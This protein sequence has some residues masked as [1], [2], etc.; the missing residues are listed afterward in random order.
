MNEGVPVTTISTARLRAEIKAEWLQHIVPFWMNLKDEQ[1]GGYYGEV[2]YEL[3]RKHN[4]P[5][6]GIATARL[7]W[8][9]AAAYRMTGDPQLAEHA[10]HAY[11]F[12]SGALTDAE[13][14][15]IYWSVDHKGK[16]LDTRKHVY[17]QAF[18]VYAL[19]EYYRATATPA[20]LEQAIALFE[21]I[22]SVG[23]DADIGAYREEF[24][25]W[26][27][28][29]PNEMLSENGV[30]AD[31]TMNTHIHVLEAYT[32]LYRV[33]Q[34]ERV[35]TALERLLIILRHH[36]YDTEQRRLHVF[37]DRNWQSLLDLTSFGHDIE[38]SWLID[39]A[40]QALAC[41]QSEYVDMVQGLADRVAEYAIQPDG[42][43]IN[44]QEHD[45]I[46]RT[47]IWWVQ[48]EAMV[49]FYN[50]YQRTGDDRFLERVAGL[51]NY[52][53]THMIDSRPGSEWFW[54]VGDDEQPGTREIAGL[55][56]CP[57]HN[58]RFCIEMMTRIDEMTA[59]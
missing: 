19:S 32:T 26:W 50:A 12:L 48:A 56:K 42:S 7:L 20:A 52:T 21:L 8:S 28:Q 51:W 4:E 54:S 39:E 35:K 2:T 30:I 46:D 29:Q 47:R 17:N 27:Q 49:G 14:Q 45:H 23:Y 34:N 11:R 5:K 43:L 24:D 9:F 3:E 40:M 6:G 59:E 31:I 10:H 25:R 16:P 44:E 55:W 22:E 58:S 18:A 53:R 15:G 33:W 13:H 37:F 57:Y 38:A 41:Q 36:M 1:Y